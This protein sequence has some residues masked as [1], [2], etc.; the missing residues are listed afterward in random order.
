MKPEFNAMHQRG[1]R[2]KDLL[3]AKELKQ[4]RA[5]KLILAFFVV[6]F[7]R[8]FASPKRGQVRA[9]QCACGFAALCLC[10]LPPC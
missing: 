6:L 3:A 9:L 5:W 10:V 4:H 1:W 2:R 7:V 8:I